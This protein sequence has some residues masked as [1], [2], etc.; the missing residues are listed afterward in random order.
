M[1]NVFTK[2]VEI[3]VYPNVGN[4]YTIIVDLENCFTNT[5]V[6]VRVEDFIDD[7]L[8]NNVDHWEVMRVLDG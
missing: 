4:A 3:R 8:S 6:Q 2:T 1:D 5:L 7:N